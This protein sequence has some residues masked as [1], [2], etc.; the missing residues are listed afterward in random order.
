MSFSKS[1]FYLCLSFLGGILLASFSKIGVIF[2]LF[3]LILFLTIFAIFYKKEIVLFGFC[4]LIFCF[5]AFWEERFE[6][7]I[8]P[9]Q[10]TFSPQDKAILEICDIHFFNEK[11]EIIFEGTILEEVEKK[12]DN[13]QIV[14]NSAQVTK[15]NYK[16]PSKGKVLAIL[17]IGSSFQYGDKL[18]VTGKL[19][20]P[21]NFISGFNWREYLRKERIYS[22][23]Y[24][25]KIKLISSV[26]GNLLLFQT[27]S[28]KR[29]LIQTAKTLPL[30]EGAIL[31][32]ITLGEESS[33]SQS[34]KEKL[35]LSGL[36]HITAVSGMNITILF[37]IFFFGLIFLDL[38][39]KEATVLTLLILI[40]YILLV[41][42][43]P[44]AIRAGIMGIF[45]YLGYAFGR[46]IKTSRLIVLTAALM[47]VQ[48]PLILTRD[49]GF[50]LSFLAFLGLVYL[51]PLLEKVMRAENSLVKKSIS[52]TLAAQ[53]FC[54]PLLIFNF[55]KLSL[56]APL[57]NILVLP[58]IPF[59]TIGGFLFLI[60]GTLIPPL[61]NLSFILYPPLKWIST[62]TE[63]TS[64]LPFSA[65]SLKLSWFFLLLAYF[66]IL[67][68]VFWAKK[69]I[70]S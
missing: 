45:L 64:S 53:I 47:T 60:L 28:F 51:T 46:L 13:I 62:V 2:Y 42:A 27:F 59:L 20:W 38:W 34:F 9:D 43:P 5:G 4:C 31:E 15:E 24:Y 69:K 8:F 1:F 30:P 68:F 11:A 56:V 39:R 29:K 36:S 21:S 65:I 61:A 58:L 14:I 25:P 41:G 17:P 44:S 12:S 23:V 18:L 26:N 70:N 7:E 52:Q 33:F 67:V 50:Q 3:T 40:F 63:I 49:V 16:I 37:G 19:H 32:G 66:L 48:N 57:S 6:K 22:I 10:C 55:G 35:S 54:F